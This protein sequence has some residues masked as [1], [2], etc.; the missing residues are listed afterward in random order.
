[1]GKAEITKQFII[2]KSAPVFN[3]RGYAGTSMND[4]T[5]ATGLTKGSIYGNF[6]NKD[7][8][9]VEAFK[10]N[11]A[12]MNAV[13]NTEMASAKSNREKLMAYPN[14][15]ERFFKGGL[16]D[17]GCPILNTSTESDDTHP[18]LKAVAKKAFLAWKKS[19]VAIIDDGKKANE[20]KPETDSEKT[21][22]TILALIEGAT[23]I[24]KLTESESNLLLINDSLKKL[25]H[26][27]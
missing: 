19:I 24:A 7:E 5:Q 25:I 16:P 20:F 27:L 12:K 13:F 23:M 14:V 6:Q 26:E 10:F 1:M 17:G 4:L 18:E 2:E 15:Y 21:G 8:V 9:A 11:T 22:I 3:K